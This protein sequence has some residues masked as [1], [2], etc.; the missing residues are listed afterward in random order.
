M[1]RKAALCLS[2]LCLFLASCAKKDAQSSAKTLTVSILPQKVLLQ[3]ILGDSTEYTINCLFEEPGNPETFDPSVSDMKS[4]SRSQAY[5]TLG[6]L[7]FEQAI[8]GRLSNGGS[9]T[10]LVNTAR[11]ID[12]LYGTHGQ[13]IAD[14]HVWLTPRNAKI[15]ASNMA[16]ELS[17][18]N[19]QNAQV[20]ADN[21][22]TLEQRLDSLDSVNRSIISG[23]GASEFMVLHPSLSYPAAE[24]GL[25]QIA[26]HGI[27]GKE[28]SVG[29]TRRRLETA[30]NA[31]AKIIVIE[32]DADRPRARA[33][34]DSSNSTAKIVVYN[35][36][37]ATWLEDFTQ[38]AS[39]ICN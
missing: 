17:K 36:M 3:Q 9:T 15:I 37:S 35:P 25:R 12:L 18:L 22:K 8:A 7:P 38:L 34:L 2:I 19:P 30:R 13:D 32:S 29:D 6:T 39:E 20:Y 26:L 28:A 16:D 27:E 33:L 31:G 1:C 11:G 14:P 24:Y 23:G 21:L 5:F 10:P 4:V